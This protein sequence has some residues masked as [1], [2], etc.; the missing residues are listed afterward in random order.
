MTNHHYLLRATTCLLAR[1][2][3]ELSPQP[4]LDW[5]VLLAY[6][7]IYIINPEVNSRFELEGISLVVNWWFDV[8]YRKKTGYN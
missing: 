2:D 4:L 7:I 3:P 5:T 1:R 8:I 6:L